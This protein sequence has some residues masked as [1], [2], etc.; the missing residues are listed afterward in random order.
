[1]D[2][3]ACC[4]LRSAVGCKPREAVLYPD[5]VAGAVPYREART[6]STHRRRARRVRTRGESRRPARPPSALRR[7]AGGRPCP[8]RRDGRD[9]AGAG[10]APRGRGVGGPG[11]TAPRRTSRVRCGDRTH[12]QDTTRTR[13]FARQDRIQIGRRSPVGH[14][15]LLAAG[16]KANL[17]ADLWS[18]QPIRTNL[19]PTVPCPS[20]L[21]DA[22][23]IHSPAYRR[24]SSFSWA[25][26]RLTF[27]P[28][29]AASHRE[30][31]QSWL[32]LRCS[33]SPSPTRT[34]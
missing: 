27:S 18:F 15:E 14:H 13:R 19:D 33:G 31:A 3:Y 9:R 4:G 26:W 32:S 5:T 17:T 29:E 1:M 10:H 25:P 21:G 2:A 24:C 7:R 6:V 8:G 34:R 20:H 28:P 12:D 16:L 22:H 30:H 23:W 11:R